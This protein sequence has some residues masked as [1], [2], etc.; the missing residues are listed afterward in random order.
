MA[1]ELALVKGQG[2][3]LIPMKA[4]DIEWIQKLKPGRLVEATI[5][6]PRNYIFHKRFFA[7]LNFA[8]DY[9]EPSAITI[10]ENKNFKSV[11]KFAR[12]IADKNPSLTPNIQ[13]WLNDFSKTHNTCEITPEKNFGQFR[14][15]VTI[16]AG[17]YVSYYRIDGSVQVEAKS[18]SFAKMD[19]QEFQSLYKAVFNVLW[20]MVLSKTGMS[21][22]EVEQIL[23]QMLEFDS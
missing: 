5:S 23:N 1:A 22:D 10:K 17:H 18:I 16:M 21:Y 13:A 4:S 3:T 19:D 20:K 8:F 15:D 12:F 14:K 9:W 11:R 2:N 6:Q 7:L